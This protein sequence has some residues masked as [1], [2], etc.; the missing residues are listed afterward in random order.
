[1]KKKDFTN[2]SGKLIEAQDPMLGDYYYFMPDEP[3]INIP[4][5]QET[6]LLL[7]E[8]ERHFGSLK[9]LSGAGSGLPDPQVFIDPNLY[10][11]KEAVLSSK[12]EGT[13]TTVSDVLK[14][15]IE[16]KK[17]IGMDEKEVEN[18][19]KA[20]KYGMTKIQTSKIDYTLIKEMHEI[21]LTNVRGEDK[22]PGE[23]R[24][25]QN[26][27]GS[28][29]EGIH[30]AT[31]VPPDPS[32]L[33]K[34]L[35]DF[36]NYLDRNDIPLLVQAAIM[37]YYFEIMHPFRDG[38]GRIGRLLIVLFF[39]KRNALESPIIYLS[40]YF[41]KHRSKYYKCLLN[42]SQKSEFE[43]WIRFFLNAVKVQSEDVC[44]RAE[45]LTKLRNSY[46]GKLTDMDASSKAIKALDLLF[47]NTFI[48]IKKLEEKLETT[49]PTAKK[50]IEDLIAAGI[51]R[52]IT[53]KERY[54]LY[55]AEEILNII[56]G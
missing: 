52:E 45:K 38:N 46:L 8:A 37:H 4:L 12:I 24:K 19:I 35:H 31:I 3:I 11:T 5:N 48:S 34:T 56:Q 42:V 39:C 49:F 50:A 6:I 54:K 2:P 36:I 26:W 17:N 23:F 29:D 25:I 30:N 41:E 33:I 18:Y 9:F 13:Q 40:E 28:V 43:D 32:A 15:Q 21:L 44:K 55:C 51:V 10:L 16:E 7:T 20:L 22:D 27:I 53:G 1:M 14:S 47:V